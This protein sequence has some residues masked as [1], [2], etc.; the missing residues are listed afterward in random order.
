MKKERQ[1]YFDNLIMASQEEQNMTGLLREINPQQVKEISLKEIDVN[2][3]TTG[4]PW[5][6]FQ[7]SCM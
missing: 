3:R 1:H 4:L 5:N 2:T 6:I 7:L